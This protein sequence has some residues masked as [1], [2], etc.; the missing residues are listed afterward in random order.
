MRLRTM[1]PNLASW[2]SELIQQNEVAMRIDLFS[3]ISHELGIASVGKTGRRPV[4][5]IN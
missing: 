3:V 5:A 2:R 4:S 1:T